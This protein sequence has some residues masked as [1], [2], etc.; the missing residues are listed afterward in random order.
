[1]AETLRIANA[2]INKVGGVEKVQ[3]RR[4]D[5]E[6]EVRHIPGLKTNLISLM[7]FEGLQVFIKWW[8]TRNFQ[9]EKVML[10]WI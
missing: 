4:V 1:M 5:S 8:T 6:T 10:H 7:T 3:L 9:G 2:T